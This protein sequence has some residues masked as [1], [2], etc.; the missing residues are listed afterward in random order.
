MTRHIFVFSESHVSSKY[1]GNIFKMIERRRCLAE[2][3]RCLVRHYL[4]HI[5]KAQGTMEL[6]ITARCG[7]YLAHKYKTRL[8]LSFSAYTFGFKAVPVTSYRD[9]LRSRPLSDSCYVCPPCLYP[10]RI[11]NVTLSAKSSL[12]LVE[13][14][15]GFRRESHK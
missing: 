15:A 7:V 6:Y 9:C 10:Y 1:R 5:F 3:E 11:R 4:L 8:G 12:I 2:K 14:K 13:N